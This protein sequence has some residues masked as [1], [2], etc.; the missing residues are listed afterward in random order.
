MERYFIL[1]NSQSLEVVSAPFETQP[2]NS[3]L[4]FVNS[5]T[6]PIFNV[7]PN[8]TNVIEGATQL[9]IDEVIA[10]KEDAED[11]QDLIND[12][13]KGQD[14]YLRTKKRLIRRIKKGLI[15]RPQAKKVRTILN[16][17][18]QF[19]KT[20]DLDIAN[21]M[22]IALAVDA[23]A[24]VQGELVWFKARILEIQ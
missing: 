8:P 3:I 7:Y 19:L 11:L 6:K 12:E 18:F 5:F 4:Y 9:E 10:L 15:T 1:A 22:A 17:I 21:D 13:T 23:N 16:P 24:N 14:L 20:G 2:E